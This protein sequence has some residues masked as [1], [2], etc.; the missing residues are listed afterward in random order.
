MQVDAMS[1]ILRPRTTWEGCD[2]GV[3]LLQSHLPSVFACHIAVLLPWLALCLA[4]FDVAPWLPP[5]LLW[6]SKPWLDRTILFALSRALFGQGTTPADV[7]RAEHGVL[8]RQLAA[9]LTLRRL[10]ASRT[11]TQ[12]IYQ[13]EG[14]EGPALRARLRQMA[15]KHRGVARLMTQSFAAAEL[16]LVASLFSLQVWLAP[17]RLPVSWNA[18][19]LGAN[20]EQLLAIIAY[21]A[22]IAF[23][24]PFYVAAGFGMYLNRRVEL[25][26]WDI[27]QE[28]RRAFAT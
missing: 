16:G 7:W 15:T 18:F 13:L 23:V 21:G 22:A 25:E 17:H 24:E 27:E 5:L 4:T 19:S 10:S 26:A 2:L 11:F 6:L 9:T 28:F 3:R 1:V 20:G 14:L 12:P 8:W